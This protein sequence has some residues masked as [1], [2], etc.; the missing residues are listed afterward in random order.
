MTST[1]FIVLI[2]TILSLSGAF[3]NNP[4]WNR[5][6]RLILH[7]PL[8]PRSGIHSGNLLVLDFDSDSYRNLSEWES[9][10]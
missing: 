9:N 7:S 3:A 8:N 1:I 4:H 6:L 2:L 10:A 5:K